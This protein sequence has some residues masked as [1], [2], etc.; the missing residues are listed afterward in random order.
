MDE[1]ARDL[2]RIRT[3]LATEHQTAALLL[4]YCVRARIMYLLRCL[5][6]AT[7]VPIATRFFGMLED[8][9][10]D[11]LLPPGS[12]LPEAALAM[13]RLRPREG[14]LGFSAPAEQLAAVAYVGA[15]VDA[16]RLIFEICPELRDHLDIT[17][18]ASDEFVQGLHGID[19]LR[20]LA[21]AVQRLP[22]ATVQQLAELVAVPPPP[23]SPPASPPPAA[24]PAPE[25][26]P[27][28]APIPTATPELRY[29]Q[30]LLSR[31]IYQQ[32]QLHL[33]GTLLAGDD[34]ACARHLSQCGWL[35]TAWLR[36]LPRRDT[37]IDSTTYLLNLAMFLGL[38][39]A[40][41][42][43]R[44]CQCGEVLSAETGVGHANRCIHH[45]KRT[46]HDTVG[47]GFDAVVRTICPSS[48]WLGEG[49]EAPAI[50]TVQR[51]EWVDGRRQLVEHAV[52]PDRT[53]SGMP[54][55][56]PTQRR[57]VD[58]K[59]VDPCGLSFTRRAGGSA[60]TPLLAAED[61]HARTVRHYSAPGL[62]ASTDVVMPVVV[63]VYGGLHTSVREQL[64]R[65]VLAAQGG[66]VQRAAQMM[67]LI[68]QEW[69]LW[70]LRARVGHVRTAMEHRLTRW[71]QL[72][73]EAAEGQLGVV[74]R[75]REVMRAWQSDSAL[76]WSI[77][78]IRAGSF[79]SFR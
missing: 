42:G 6:P 52:R 35:G 57:H 60:E 59:V 51:E 39:V 73:R 29:T 7:T 69:S 64:W 1:T 23:P 46:R 11:W 49:S 37:A 66:H 40:G 76:A 48:V 53:G 2:Q 30:R 33:R 25:P 70:L 47:R 19:F 17:A 22:D 12:A 4:R 43:G 67:C 71:E 18:L 56:P 24:S 13:L 26:A 58:F 31:S 50:G 8:Y 3:V 45:E 21:D 78:R 77:G 28:P 75:P 20:G 10:R 14:G 74:S 79:G 65:W 63:E 72:Q 16:S 38:A 5:P 55:D 62:V 34:E 36:V 54:G 27:E 44:Q 41:F 15:T 9:V 32:L 68:Q 61:M